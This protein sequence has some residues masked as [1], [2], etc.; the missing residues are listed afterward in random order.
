MNPGRTGAP[1]RFIRSEASKAHFSPSLVGVPVAVRLRSAHIPRA[2]AGISKITFNP[3]TTLSGAN[4]TRDRASAQRV[5]LV[6]LPLKLVGAEASPV[7]AVI[8]EA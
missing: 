8:L 5:T 7:R 4:V 2:M 6:A 1:A 3:V